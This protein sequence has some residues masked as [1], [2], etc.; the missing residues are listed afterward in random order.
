MAGLQS[1]GEDGLQNEVLVY[2]TAGTQVL[3]RVTDSAANGQPMCAVLSEDQ[4]TLVTAY[5]SYDGS[6]L[7]GRVTFFDLSVSGGIYQDRIQANFT[8]SDLI[9][10]DLYLQGSS[11]GRCGRQPDCRL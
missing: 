1:V 2:D 8:Y 9:I 5:T 11:S 3:R 7:T 4:K 10:A 6:S